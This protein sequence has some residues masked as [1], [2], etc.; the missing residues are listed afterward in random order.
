MLDKSSDKELQLA[1]LAQVVDEFL[2]DK[3]ESEKRSENSSILKSVS[4]KGKST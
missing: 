1:A 2:S 4:I 3:R